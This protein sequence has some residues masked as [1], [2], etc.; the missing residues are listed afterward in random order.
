MTLYTIGHSNRSFEEFTAE[1]STRGIE[2]VVDV[3]SSPYSRYATQ[4][5]TDQIRD[6]LDRLGIDYRFAG[7]ALGGRPREA[8]LYRDGQASYATMKETYAFRR[9][10]EQLLDIAAR[11]CTVLMCSEGQAQDC[12]RGILIAPAADE[13]ADVVHI[14]R[15]GCDEPH[16]EMVR[17][18][19]ALHM[20]ELGLFDDQPSDPLQFALERQGHRIAYTR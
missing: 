17:R 18:L 14:G 7:G 6:G 2:V 4:F 16:A 12:H 8:A 11:R 13:Y 10:I 3:R 19:I 5:N 9:G 15:D 20:N 1:L